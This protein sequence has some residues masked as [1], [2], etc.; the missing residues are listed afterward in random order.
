MNKMY[1]QKVVY[2]HYKKKVILQIEARYIIQFIFLTKMKTLQKINMKL[3]FNNTEMFSNLLSL[4]YYF[5]ILALLL[6]MRVFDESV[7]SM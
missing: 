4:L 5:L 7:N 1:I 6:I 2:T 3:S